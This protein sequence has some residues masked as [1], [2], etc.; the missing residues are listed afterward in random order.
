[1][2]ISRTSRRTLLTR[3]LRT[4]ALVGAA[5]IARAAAAAAAVASVAARSAHAAPT[6]V[7]VTRTG[8]PFAL[9]IPTAGIAAAVETVWL[10]APA[11]RAPGQVDRVSLEGL[12]AEIGLPADP[13]A[14]GWYALSAIPGEPGSAVLVGHVD[15]AFGPAVFT[16]LPQLRLGAEIAL[17]L[18]GGTSATFVVDGLRRH[19]AHLAAPA[20]LF[21][22]GGDARLH[23]VTC[24]GRFVRGAGGYQERLIVS[25]LHLPPPPPASQV[26]DA[27]E[28]TAPDTPDGETP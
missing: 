21:T 10:T 12:Q 22:L 5:P 13:D 16:R 26:L 3:A 20:D 28:V 14:A 8:S 7:A 23:L 15:T 1:M 9:R 4:S 18:A 24:T 2:S 6:T 19:P 11:A 27:P 17:D 25:A